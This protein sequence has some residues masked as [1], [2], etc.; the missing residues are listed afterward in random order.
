[1]SEQKRDG[2]SPPEGESGLSILLKVALFVAIPAAIFA[3]IKSLVG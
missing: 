2:E 3:F 1:M